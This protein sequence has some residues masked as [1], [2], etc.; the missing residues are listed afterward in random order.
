M[1][2][3][4]GGNLHMVPLETTNVVVCKRSTKS[5]RMQFPPVNSTKHGQFIKKPFLKKSRTMASI[6]IEGLTP[7]K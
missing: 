2:H 7:E 4:H 6:N 1:E 5:D 3:W